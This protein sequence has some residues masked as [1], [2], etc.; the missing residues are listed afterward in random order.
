MEKILQLKAVL[1]GCDAVIIGAGSGLSASAGYEY[2]GAKF[3]EDFKDFIDK[4]GFTDLYSASFFEFTDQREKWAFWSRFIYANRYVMPPKPVYANLLR[5]VQDKDYFVITTNVDHV[6][7]RSGFD[8]QRLFYTQGD[9]GLWQCATPCHSKTYDNETQVLQMLKEQRS[10]QIP[11]ELVPHCPVCNGMMEANLRKDGTFVQD[12][13]WYR[14]SQRYTD[15]LHNHS[16]GK[17]VYLDLG[18]GMNT[19][20]IFKYPFMQMT[21]ANSQATYV[22]INKGQNFTAREISQRSILID[23]DIGEVLEKLLA[24]E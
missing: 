15:F 7:Q 18:S 11:E 8:K 16:E 24:V 3:E 19:P 14:A 6:F 9:Y 17:V 10:M 2:A 1:D 21:L 13:G 23:G 12:E 22:S 20:A 5:A 4:Y